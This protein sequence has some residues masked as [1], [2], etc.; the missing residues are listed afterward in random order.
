MRNNSAI[1]RVVT[2]A[3]IL[4]ALALAAC[5][6]SSGAS[7]AAPS[8]A[9]PSTA[10]PTTVRP[11]TTTAKPKPKPTITAAPQPTTTT[12]PAKVRAA[13]QTLCDG[14]ASGDAET[15][16]LVVSSDPVTKAGLSE[17]CTVPASLVMD[18][19]DPVF[20]GYPLVVPTSSI[21]RRVRA[22]TTTDQVVA[23]APGV[24]AAFNPLVPEP[25]KYLT[26]PNDGD[27]VMRHTYFP[28]TGGSCWN[29]VQRGSAEPA[30]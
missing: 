17:H 14:I 27:C 10:A 28:N 1:K 18:S 16:N 13:I 30:A 6:G 9:A 20:P 21:D 25:W 8:A 12:L 24:Y 26:G 15:I 2:R 11:T 23:L 29:G 5:G 22:S 7:E 3:L 4:G 19:G